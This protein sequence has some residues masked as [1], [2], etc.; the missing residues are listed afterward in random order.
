MCTYDENSFMV[1][2]M[3][4]C[5]R[6]LSKNS[7]NMNQTMP[8]DN[9]I[10]T[11]ALNNNNGANLLQEELLALFK[12]ISENIFDGVSNFVYFKNHILLFFLLGNLVLE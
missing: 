2:H 1:K 9:T 3:R 10:N 4:R 7:M 6:S 11:V 12:R 8:S 5:V